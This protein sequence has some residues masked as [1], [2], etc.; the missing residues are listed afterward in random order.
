MLDDS[1]PGP[2]EVD[3]AGAS[4]I[5]QGKGLIWRCLDTGMPIYQRRLSMAEVK[6]R[7]N[8]CWRPYHAALA[9]AVQAACRRHGYSIHLNCHS[10]PAVA[11]AFSTDFPG[12]AHA[13]FVVGYRDGTAADARLSHRVCAH[14]E[15]LGYSVSYNPPYKGVELVRRH[16]DP[17]VQ[18]HNIQPKINRRLY[19]DKV[20]LEI[21]AP[22]FHRLSANLRLLV[23]RLLA[24]DPRRLG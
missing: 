14:L 20:T 18:Q 11:S 5:R 19:M 10:M 1:W 12:L 23:E 9:N 24:T 2:L 21:G 13:D 22:A 16:G 6:V 4:K 8:Q 17:A 3:A 7:I 15:S